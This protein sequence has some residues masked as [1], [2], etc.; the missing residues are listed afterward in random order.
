M[1]SG[2]DGTIYSRLFTVESKINSLDIAKDNNVFAYAVENPA[3]IIIGSLDSLENKC[4]I[5]PSRKIEDTVTSETQDN[6]KLVATSISFSK[7]G[8]F[9]AAR[10]LGGEVK[11]WDASTCE[12]H[13]QI[14]LDLKNV[15]TK[16]SYDEFVAYKVI[17]I[18]NDKL[19][20][21]DQKAGHTHI[22]IFDFTTGKIIKEKVYEL[23]ISDG[24]KFIVNN[25]GDLLAIFFDRKG[26]YVV[27]L[28]TFNT[29]YTVVGSYPSFS[30]D[31]RFLAI[32]KPSSSS[33]LVG[34][35]ALLDTYSGKEIKTISD[36]KSNFRD[37]S[38]NPNGKVLAINARDKKSY[39]IDF[40]D[41]EKNELITSIKN[42]NYELT[43][44]V[45]FSSNGERMI[46]RGN[47]LNN[48]AL[49]GIYSATPLPK[50]NQEDVD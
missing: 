27:E 42:E 4:V 34:K 18:Q 44:S 22:R 45:D 30:P 11:I 6:N 14:N 40:W 10:M 5:F 20:L 9:L 39:R 38:F 1:S 19:L 24:D 25:R 26:T 17:F 16:E 37:I 33:L 32:N 49:L 43:N 15:F 48:K 41:T 36:G 8:K 47:Y 7:N 50:I 21:V 13:Q 35:I 12:A 31:N 28:D 29:L 46:V 3:H 2:F 23:L